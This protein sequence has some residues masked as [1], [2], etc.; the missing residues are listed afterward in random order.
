MKSKQESISNFVSTLKIYI[1]FVNR[2]VEYKDDKPEYDYK[3]TD[4]AD[5]VFEYVV[6]CVF[7]KYTGWKHENEF[8]FVLME[9]E[10]KGDYIAVNS[11][12]KEYYLGCK[13]ESKSNT[14]K[15][16]AS[17]GSVV[18]FLKNHLIDIN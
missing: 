14:V 1:R 17:K 12:V 3:M 7:T 9:N 10:F 13:V 5:N 2:S 18:K 11:L 4:L 16:L 15:Y 6:R 8:R